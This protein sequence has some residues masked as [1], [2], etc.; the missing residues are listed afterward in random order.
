MSVNVIS[1]PNTSSVARPT[2]M[3][4]S[5]FTRG[6]TVRARFLC[7]VALR[8]SARGLPLFVLS[9]SSLPSAARIFLPFASLHNRRRYLS[10]RCHASC[11]ALR[12]FI[13]ALSDWQSPSH[14][15]SVQQ[16]RSPPSPEAPCASFV[17]AEEHGRVLKKTG[18]AVPLSVQPRILDTV[19]ERACGSGL[20]YRS[21]LFVRRGY[22]PA[23]IF[24]VDDVSG[25]RLPSDAG[26]AASATME[27][28]SGC[29]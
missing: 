22:S 25:G 17:L 28:R 15:F 21:V 23:T 11:A 2:P 3:R 26:P 8:D 10:R 7:L 27:V 5:G 12:W 9:P 16:Q 1:V 19:F 24:G 14:S 29:R 13:C 6:C 4:V 20:C 18:V